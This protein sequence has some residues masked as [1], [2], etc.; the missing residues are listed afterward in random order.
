MKRLISIMLLITIALMFSGCVIV[1]AHYHR[2]Y[3]RHYSGVVVTNYPPPPPPRP[4][5][6]IRSS[7]P[8]P[9][10]PVVIVRPAP[11]PHH[12]G[13]PGRGPEGRRDLRR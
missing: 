1:D 8:P 5:Y 9:P 11:A 12:D 6:V 4:V 13:G 10:P 7:P 2:G 3:G